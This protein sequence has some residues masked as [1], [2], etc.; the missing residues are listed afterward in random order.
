MLTFS[1]NRAGKE[2]PASRE[3]TRERAKDELRRR[4]GRA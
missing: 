4:F 1:I 2:L 3:R